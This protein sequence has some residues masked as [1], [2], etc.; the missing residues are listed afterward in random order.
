MSDKVSYEHGARKLMAQDGP[1]P[2]DEFSQK[3][4]GN[5]KPALGVGLTEKVDSKR[6][7]R[8][9]GDKEAP[10]KPDPRDRP[11]RDTREAPATNPGEEAERIVDADG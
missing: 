6:K 5:R 7:P 3:A 2:S 10:P 9:P 8:R 4:A 1:D 11:P